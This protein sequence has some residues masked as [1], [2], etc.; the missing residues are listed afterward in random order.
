MEDTVCNENNGDGDKS[1]DPLDE[2]IYAD[3]LD[4]GMRVDDADAP[5]A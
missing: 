1:V 2:G 3:P 4:E 5:V